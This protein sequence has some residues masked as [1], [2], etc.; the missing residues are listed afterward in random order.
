MTFY[1][2]ISALL[3]LGS[4]RVLLSFLE[5]GCWT[6]VPSAALLVVLV[7]NDMLS[8]SHSIECNP[9]INYTLPMMMIDLA[10]FLLLS[11]AMV[12]LSPAENLFG[13]SLPRIAGFLSPPSFWALLALYWVA[14]IQWTR[15]SEKE[16]PP[17]SSIL[18]AL[19]WLVSALFLGQGILSELG[20]K[21]TSL[22]GGWVI[23]AYVVVYL[24]CLRPLFPS[25][26]H[27]DR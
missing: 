17:Q 11:L 7:F 8:T 5:K 26:G 16:E 9:S 4:L 21:I 18:V 12:V 14:L 19:R 22:I 13:V 10:N 2:V 25:Q 1:N 27:G 6:D 3:F 23:L 15:I 24:T 20:F